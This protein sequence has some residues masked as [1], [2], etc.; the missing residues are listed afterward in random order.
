MESQTGA[1]K[2]IAVA[3]HFK[4]IS[5]PSGVGGGKVT[6]QSAT[7]HQARSARLMACYFVNG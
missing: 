6:K 3:E 7:G 2:P 4:M 1:P 5:R